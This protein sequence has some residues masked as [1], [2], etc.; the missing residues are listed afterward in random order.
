[1]VHPI[2]GAIRDIPQSEV[3]KHLAEGWEIDERNSKPKKKAQKKE[4]K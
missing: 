2:G 1:M 4:S 3:E